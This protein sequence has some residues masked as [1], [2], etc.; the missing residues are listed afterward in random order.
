MFHVELRQFPH[1]ARAFNLT[2]EEL[3]ERIVAP[4]VRG[5][6]LELQERRWL[7]DRAKLV[8]Y[9][10]PRL[11]TADMGMG[12]GWGNVTKTGS[13]VTAAVLEAARPRPPAPAALEELVTALAARSS[14]APLTLADALEIVSESAPGVSAEQVVWQLLAEGRLELVVAARPGER[15][16]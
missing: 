5:A 8:I 15:G 14:L 3:R 13:E 12:R 1:V 9:E 7:P 11:A 2:E 6:P 16:G 4:W 10:G